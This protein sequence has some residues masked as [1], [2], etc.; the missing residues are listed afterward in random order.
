MGSFRSFLAFF[1][2]ADG[3]NQQIQ[4]IKKTKDKKDNTHTTTH[5][6]TNNGFCSS[7]IYPRESTKRRKERQGRTLR[8]SLIM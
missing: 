2:V 8:F 6:P 5:K 7:K 3:C 4:K 1:G